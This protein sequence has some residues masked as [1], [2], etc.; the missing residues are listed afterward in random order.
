MASVKAAFSVFVDEATVA[1]SSTTLKTTSTI[2]TATSITTISSSFSVF[3]EHEKE[4]IDPLTGLRVNAPAPKSKK[5]KAVLASKAAQP[6]LENFNPLKSKADGDT[7]KSKPKAG[8]S[9]KKTTKARKPKARSRSPSLPILQEDEEELPRSQADI[10]SRCY[11]LTVL[12]LADVSEAYEG[13]SPSKRRA[14]PPSPV[15]MQRDKSLEPEISDTFI[16][17]ALDLGIKPRLRSTSP[18]AEAPQTFSTPERKQIYSNFT[19]SSPSKSAE[20]YRRVRER[21]LSPEEADTLEL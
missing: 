2:T 6:L 17:S 18:A 1:E 20:R 5:R 15:K 21:S 9:K 11:E 8:S 16:P 7:K 19:F 10:D 4:N 13:G 3:L 14:L 12:P